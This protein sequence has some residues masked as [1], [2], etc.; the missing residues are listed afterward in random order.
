MCKLNNN[1]NSNKNEWNRLTITAKDLPITLILNLTYKITKIIN[2]NIKL[3][4]P[5]LTII[6][7]I[8]I[9]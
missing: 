4:N 2:L 7:I 6:S 8:I 9:N 3:S 5:M 1:N